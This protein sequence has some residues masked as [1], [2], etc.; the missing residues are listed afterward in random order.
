LG[1]QAYFITAKSLTGQQCD[2]IFD[3]PVSGDKIHAVGELPGLSDRRWKCG[4]G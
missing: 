2:R 3:M 1:I 4:F